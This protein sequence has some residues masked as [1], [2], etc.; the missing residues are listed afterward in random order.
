MTEEMDTLRLLPH[1][2][3]AS[4]V[5][6]SQWGTPERAMP[7][8]QARAAIDLW[9]SDGIATLGGDIWLAY[10]GADGY[11]P[12]VEPW[13]VDRSNQESWHAYVQ[14]AALRAMGHLDAVE[15]VMQE[16]DIFVVVVTAT[17]DEYSSLVP[18]R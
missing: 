7:I 13:S 1:H 14:R 11:H 8:R 4:L 12:A 10:P 3:R 16:R 17:E 2:I 6:L 5:D 9:A 15:Q 18:P